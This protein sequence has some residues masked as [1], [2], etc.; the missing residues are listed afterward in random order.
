M[1]VFT[2]AV[3]FTL[4][5]EQRGDIWWVNYQEES[6]PGWGPV[7]ESEWHVWAVLCTLG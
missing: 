2:Q 6:I 4:G 3:I 7:S 5:E 1:K